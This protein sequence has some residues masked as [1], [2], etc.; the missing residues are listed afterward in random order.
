[1]KFNDYRF[2]R[3]RVVIGSNLQALLYAYSNNLTVISAGYARPGF[4]EFFDAKTDLSKFNLINEAMTLEASTGELIS[5]GLPYS[6]LWGKL[7]S[8]LSLAGNAPFMDRAAAIRLEEKNLIRIAT[9]GSRVARIEFEEATVFQDDLDGIDAELIQQ[10]PDLYK[11]IDWFDIRSG[12]NQKIDYFDTGEDF[13][14]KIFLYPSDNVD[15]FSLR[16]K[17]A[18][19]ISFLTREQL[20]D[21]EYSDTYARFKVLKIFKEAGMRGASNGVRVGKG[22]KRNFYPLKIETEE[23]TVSKIHRN[24]YR[25]KDNIKFNYQSVDELLNIDII[26]NNPVHRLNN[27]FI[28]DK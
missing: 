25:D 28:Q 4:F 3:E 18:A 17:D 26:E 6:D 15:G 13:V 24:K 7:A 16:S 12:G 1:M 5:F 9:K 10:A 22:G 21:F 8:V 27:F 19:S 23:R 11:V 20:S 2:K 14:N